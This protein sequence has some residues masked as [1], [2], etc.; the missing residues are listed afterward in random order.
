MVGADAIVVGP[1]D[2]LVL[3]VADDL[4]DEVLK[5]F[6]ETLRDLGLGERVLIVAG[7]IEMAKVQK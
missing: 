2:F 7:V 4:P 6:S 5:G 1:D 3:R